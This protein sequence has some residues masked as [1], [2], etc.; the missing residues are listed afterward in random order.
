MNRLDKTESAVFFSCSF[1]L[2]LR[3]PFFQIIYT[4][5]YKFSEKFLVE[6]E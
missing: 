1:S 6:A 2:F 4:K 5:A 3:D